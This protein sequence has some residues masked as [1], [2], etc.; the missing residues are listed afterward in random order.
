V[1]LL[2]DAAHPTMQY[3]AQGACMAMEDAVCLADKL[4]NHRGDF[5]T[6]FVEY[7][8]SRY[9]RT[10]RVQLTSRLYGDIYHAES[11]TAELRDMMLGGRDPEAAY[12]G[13][14]WLYE[15]VDSQGGQIL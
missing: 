3:L 5:K 1:T 15:G 10:A 2:G 4:Q 7:Q 11:A 13:M 12:A 8:Q 6:A 9:L 14:K